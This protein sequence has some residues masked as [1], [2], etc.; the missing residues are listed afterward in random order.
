MASRFSAALPVER[1]VTKV[2]S[3]SYPNKHSGTPVSTSRM[4]TRTAYVPGVSGVR[5]S[6]QTRLPEPGRRSTDACQAP[7]IHRL[8]SAVQMVK[9]QLAHST[10]PVAW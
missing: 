10:S 1:I 2:G 7:A 6:Q 9:P 4:A 3:F 8:R 5:G